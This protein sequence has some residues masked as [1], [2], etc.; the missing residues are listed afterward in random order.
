MTIVRMPAI[1]VFWVAATGA[2]PIDPGLPVPIFEGDLII[3]GGM[4]GLRMYNESA[5]PVHIKVHLFKDAL[6][7]DYTNVVTPQY[8][9][10]DITMVPDYKKGLG[11]LLYTKEVL[12]E[13][14]MTSVIEWRLP[15]QKV[16]QHIWNNGASR[17]QWW[18]MASD[19]DTTLQSSVRLIGYSNLSFTGD[20]I[21]PGT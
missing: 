16:D 3:R 17:Y 21:T 11:R 13:S 1:D 15:I 14:L 18:V 8:V 20:V 19:M 9:G 6:T 5:T 12:L 2:L 4:L 7:P 10:Y